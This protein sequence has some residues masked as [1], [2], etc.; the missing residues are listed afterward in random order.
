MSIE[1]GLNCMLF[2]AETGMP[3]WW[4]TLFLTTQLRNTGKSVSTMET[5][6]RA[7]QILFS[8]V[9]GKGIKLEE[10]F[11]TRIEAWN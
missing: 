3:T 4:P 5:A 10:R 6:L 1:K 9:E 7:I 8:F 11:L 2:D